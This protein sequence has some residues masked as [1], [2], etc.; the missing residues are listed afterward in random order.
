MIKGSYGIILRRYLADRHSRH[1]K[2]IRSTES[3][4]P[5][6]FVT[7]FGPELIK[8]YTDDGVLYL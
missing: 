4:M 3:P 5:Y 6:K 1:S 8:K 7:T 2:D